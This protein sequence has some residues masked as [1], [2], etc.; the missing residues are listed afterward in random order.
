MAGQP[1]F[2]LGQDSG[3]HL[4]TIFSLSSTHTYYSI[5]YI[6]F[7]QYSTLIHV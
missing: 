4:T 7:T 6:L 5:H 2:D 1:G 3:L